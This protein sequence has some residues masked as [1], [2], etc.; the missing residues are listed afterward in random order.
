MGCQAFAQ[1]SAT[2][3]LFQTGLKFCFILNEPENP[4][5]HHEN[6]SHGGCLIAWALAAL[7]SPGKAR[8]QDHSG[9]K[10]LALRKI[11]W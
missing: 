5:Q 9:Q 4:W 10:S 2:L 3:E 7:K 8:T 11:L 1:Q 6:K